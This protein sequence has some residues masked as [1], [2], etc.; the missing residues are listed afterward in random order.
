[1]YAPGADVL[2]VPGGGWIARAETGAWAEA[3]R[4]D[5][6]PL[7]KAAADAGVLMAGVCTGS[8]LLARAGVIGDRPATTHHGAKAELEA[9]G[10]KVADGRV[11]DAGGLVTAGGVTSGIDLALHL[12]ERIA[13]R[14]AAVA[15]AE[16]L[17]YPWSPEAGVAA[18]AAVGQTRPAGH[19]IT[20]EPVPGVVT[21][22]WGGQVVAESSSALLLRETGLPPV[23]YFPMDDVRM[24][25][26]EKTDHHSTCPF[27][28][29]ASYWAIDVG[30]RKADN[31]AWGYED[32]LPD[33]ADIKGRIAFY[34]EKLDAVYVKDS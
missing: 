21:A 2:L 23:T 9:A 17:E 26:M 18:A 16:W 33:R 24:D 12:V 31:I 29:E 15:Q 11:V 19:T 25:L 28:G 8:M 13:G 22:I 5:W 4:G 6:L 27:K 1:V 34:A 20:T 32:P 14:E 30:W 3:E 7:L 10:V